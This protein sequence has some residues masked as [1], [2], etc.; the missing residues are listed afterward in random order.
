MMQSDFLPH[1]FFHLF[2]YLRICVFSILLYFIS[3]IKLY[4][5]I[6]TLFEQKEKTT[7]SADQGHRDRRCDLRVYHISTTALRWIEP[8]WKIRFDLICAKF[9]I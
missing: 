2:A 4:Y 9:K 3:E 8:Q 7:V 5:E 1:L 6:S